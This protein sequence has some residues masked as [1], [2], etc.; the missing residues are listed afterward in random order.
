MTTQTLSRVAVLA[1]LTACTGSSYN[2]GGF[3]DGDDGS[4]GAD[5]TA[6]GSDGVGDGEDGSSDGADGTEPT[7]CTHAYHPI[8][9]SGWTKTFAATYS[10]NSGTATEEGLGPVAGEED[11]YLYRDTITTG[12]DGYS[13]EVRVGCDYD[14]EGMFVLGWDGDYTMTVLGLFPLPGTV[15]ST[16]NPHRKYLPPEYAVDNAGSWQFDYTSNMEWTM[17]M[18]GGDTGVSPATLTYS[19][20]YSELGFEA[21]TLPTGETVQAYKLIN[22][23]TSSVDLFGAPIPQEGY[24]EQWWVKGL[25]MVKEIS[26]DNADTSTPL[27][28]RTLS[29][30]SGLVAE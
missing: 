20:T 1:L 19:G 2:Q 11:V 22:E 12:T 26:Y 8:H 6:D 10:G 15:K 27:M 9:E 29:D 28:T 17:E 24:I 21:Y 23:Y 18:E 16:L 5:G 13:V 4:D 3:S 14:G 7:A 25:G 30:Y